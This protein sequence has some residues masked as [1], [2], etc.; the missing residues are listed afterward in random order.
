MD[1]QRNLSSLVWTNCLISQKMK[2]LKWLPQETLDFIFI[3]NFFFFCQ[4]S[5]VFLYWHIW[6]NSCSQT[7]SQKVKS[8]KFCV[9]SL[10]INIFFSTGKET[11]RLLL[12]LFFFISREHAVI[13]SSCS[14]GA[15]AGGVSVSPQVHLPDIQHTHSA[16]LVSRK[17]PLRGLMPRSEANG[18]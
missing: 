7:D 10:K 16:L 15:D 4:D 6:W 14:A 2:R 18:H 3:P 11:K 9:I 5:N 1:L 12:L 17:N 8:F 13:Y